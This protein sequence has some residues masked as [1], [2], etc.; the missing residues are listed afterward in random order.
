MFGNKYAA[1]E[2]ARNFKQEV[3]KLQT[4]KKKAQ[5][6][7]APVKPEVK[8]EDFL[9]SPAEEVDVHGADLNSKIEE[10]ASYAKDIPCE[11]CETIHDGE[12]C[13]CDKCGENHEGECKKEN[14]AED[15]SYLVDKKAQY[16]LFQLGKIAKGLREKNKSFAA[17]MVEVTALEIKDQVMKK[18]SQKLQIVSGLQ[19]M[20]QESYQKGDHYTGDVI[21]VTV[22]NIKK[23]K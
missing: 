10:V 12:A 14:L 19:K 13:P 1:E 4:L 5:L 18:A 11:K 23:S 17:D 15:M 22:E 8:P 21:S 9:V 6:Q 2:L 3:F 7:E 16:V 20:A